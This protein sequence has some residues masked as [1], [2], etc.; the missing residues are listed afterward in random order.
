MIMSSKKLPTAPL[1]KRPRIVFTQGGKGGESRGDDREHDADEYGHRSENPFTGVGEGSRSIENGETLVA[2]PSRG[3]TFSR[4]YVMM[5]LDWDQETVDSIEV[6]SEAG[7]ESM[8]PD[9]ITRAVP[10]G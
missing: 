1:S 10:S 8:L 6:T 4:R 7:S 9:W 5:I 3:P 2:S